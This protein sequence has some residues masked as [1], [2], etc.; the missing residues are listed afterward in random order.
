M[1]RI[2]CPCGTLVYDDKKT[3]RK[4][5]EKL[6]KMQVNKKDAIATYEGIFSFENGEKRLRIILE[7]VIYNMAVAD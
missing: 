7:K 3:F 4:Q 1:Q 2:T 5:I 6:K